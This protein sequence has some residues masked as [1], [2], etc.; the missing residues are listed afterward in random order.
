MAID[1]SDYY[2]RYGP[3]V[4]RRCRQLLKEQTKAED[5]MHD[6]FVELLR[7][8]GQLHEQAPS[9]LLYRIATNVSLNRLRSERRR[10]VTSDDSLLERIAALGDGEGEGSVSA[11]RQLL[12]RLFGSEPESTR[13]IAV[14]HLQDGLTLEQVAEEVQMS[15]SGVR[16]RLRRLRTQLQELERN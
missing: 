12:S 2:Q 7:R 14:L 13:V 16:K 11:A 3:M 15:V 1:V 4:L 9:S 5:A 10:P 6:V 8:E